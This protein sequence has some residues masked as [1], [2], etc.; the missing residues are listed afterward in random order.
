M[1]LRPLLEDEEY[2]QKLRQGALELQSLLLDLKHIDLDVDLTSDGHDQIT[3]IYAD[4]GG[5]VRGTIKLTVVGSA[6]GKS[7]TVY[8]AWTI[9][10]GVVQ[11][12]NEGF[13]ASMI[14]FRLFNNDTP[15][16]SF[17][18][19]VISTFGTNA[20]TS[21]DKARLPKDEVYGAIL[22]PPFTL[23][24]RGEHT[25]MVHNTRIVSMLEVCITSASTVRIHLHDINGDTH[26]FE[27]PSLI[28]L[29]PKLREFIRTAQEAL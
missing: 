14:L 2:Q 18:Q 11:H 6:L 15:F 28:R 26:D 12:S 20:V 22:S 19:S 7:K 27:G 16:K 23:A 25:M 21:I 8:R 9:D 1:K 10:D 3:V 24:E 13:N 17:E 4:K 5:L 29:I